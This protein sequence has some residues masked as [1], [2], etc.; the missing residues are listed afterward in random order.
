MGVELIRIPK[1]EMFTKDNIQIASEILKYISKIENRNFSPEI[2]D[3]I[4][5]VSQ[6]CRFEVIPSRDENIVLDVCHNIDGFNA[7]IQ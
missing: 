1:H 4:N 2:E 5:N 3:L 6:P 7:V